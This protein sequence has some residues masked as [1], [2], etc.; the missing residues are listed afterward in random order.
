MRDDR[1]A[2]VSANHTDP[3]LADEAEQILAGLTARQKK[4][5]PKYFYD[6]TGSRLFNEICELPEYYL[7]RTERWIMERYLRE[8]AALIGP[9]VSVIEF[10]SGSSTKIRLLLD[11]LV[12]QPHMCPWTYRRSIF[13]A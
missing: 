3:A 11:N 7:T 1:T 4:L 13:P 10:G 12:E 9:R 8:M 6:E 2:L 5:S